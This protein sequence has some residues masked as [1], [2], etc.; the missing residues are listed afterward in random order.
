MKAEYSGTMDLF[1]KVMQAY[2]Q[3]P[4]DVRGK[5]VDDAFFGI[6]R[7]HIEPDYSIEKLGDQMSRGCENLQ[8]VV[9]K[10]IRHTYVIPSLH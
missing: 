2:A 9:M 6:I 8:N 4:G 5:E 10:R 3:I 1:S 7:T